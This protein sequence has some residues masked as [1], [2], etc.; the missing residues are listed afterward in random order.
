[1]KNRDYHIPFSGLKDGKHHFEFALDN[2]FFTTYAFEE[3]NAAH[4]QVSVELNKLSTFMELDFKATGSV[5]I[6]CDTTNE[7]FDLPIEAAIELVVKFGDEFDN[8]NES[9]L[10]LPHGEHQVDVA[11]YMYEMVVLAVPAKRVHPGVLD[12]SLES[13]VLET[14]EK[15]GVKELKEQKE[16][17]EETDPRWD[18]LKKLLTDK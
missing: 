13:E 15:L 5:N 9:L 8:E 7:P 1:M 18:A 17:I 14:L 10:V 6:N 12:G 11:Q 3:F 16:E 4:I 2:T